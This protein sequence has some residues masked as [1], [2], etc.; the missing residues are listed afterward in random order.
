MNRR[1]LLALLTATLSTTGYAQQD[2]VPPTKP[3]TIFLLRHS[4]TAADTRE[5]TDP[6]LSAEG[7]QRA[8]DLVQLLG[9]AE[10][11]HAFSSEF[12]R[13][14]GVLIPLA[15]TAKVEIE[16]IKSLDSAQQL[17]ALRELPPGSV[18]VVA[19][20]SNTIPRLLSS[21]GGEAKNLIRGNLDHDSYDRVFCITMPSG[22]S[23]TNTIE[24]RY[25][26]PCVLK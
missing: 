16:T 9:H 11:T 15:Q 1:F 4:E 6:E 26:K 14:R 19:G 20:H 17:T 18:A 23:A 3:V 22:G 7:L 13:T 2:S 25:G 10:I 8:K 24:L 21:L 12:N 5:N